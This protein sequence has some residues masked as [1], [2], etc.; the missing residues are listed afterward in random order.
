MKKGLRFSKPERIPRS[1]IEIMNDL[2]T[3]PSAFGPRR[4]VLFKK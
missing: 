2:S 3:N 1:E 4:Q